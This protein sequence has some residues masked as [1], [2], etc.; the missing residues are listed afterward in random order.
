MFRVKESG[1]YS[2]KVFNSYNCSFSD[3]I[4]IA[5]ECPTLIYIPDAFTPNNDGHN[6]LFQIIANNIKEFDLVIFDRWGEKVF[7]T[8]DPQ[9]GWDGTYNSS[10]CVDGV[11]YYQFLMKDSHGKAHGKTGTLTLMR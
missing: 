8:T 5:E 10:N 9:Q 3:T 7:H 6:D 11:Y 2:V 1:I 4:F